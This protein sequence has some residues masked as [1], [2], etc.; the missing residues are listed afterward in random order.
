M[1]EI[2]HKTSIIVIVYK[3]FILPRVAWKVAKRFPGGFVAASSYWFC[4]SSFEFKF[5]AI[6]SVVQEWFIPSLRVC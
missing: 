4:F 1:R 5:F 2:N 6:L 3:L